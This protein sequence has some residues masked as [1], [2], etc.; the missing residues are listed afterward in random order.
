M[1][2][3]PDRDTNL[4][5]IVTR[6]LQGDTMSSLDVYNLTEHLSWK[7]IDLMKENELIVK[8]KIKSRQYSAETI[9]I[10]IN[11]YIKRI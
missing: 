4:K 5:D 7:S 11:K 2:R 6:I 3:P 8:K 9:I 10:T 1:V